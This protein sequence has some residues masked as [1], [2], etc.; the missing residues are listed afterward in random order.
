MAD[1]QSGFL[2]PEPA[3]PEPEIAAS[4]PSSAPPGPQ[5]PQPGY[6]QQAWYPP[7]GPGYGQAPWGYAPPQ[8][9]NNPAI[10]GF[11]LS[12]VS[13]GLLVFTIGISSIVSLGCSIAA[14]VL[15]RKGVKKVDAGD[16]PKHKG[17]AQAGFWLGI[18][19]IVLAALAT[20]LWT[21][22]AVAAITDEDFRRDLED[23]LDD[24]RTLSMLVPLVVRLGA[25]LLT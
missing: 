2:P 17:L 10:A 18:A 14:V 8:P 25:L 24:S 5:A 21:I 9:D 11:V 7:Q 6:G 3:G 19:G 22:V 23:D 4:P 12:L 16:S 15:G 20:A 1:G 13:L